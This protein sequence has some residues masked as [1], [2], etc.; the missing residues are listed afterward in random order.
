[1]ITTLLFD[2]VGHVDDE[3]LDLYCGRRLPP[4]DDEAVCQHL[5]VCGHCRNRARREAFFGAL[6]ADNR[7]LFEPPP[8]P[9]SQRRGRLFSPNL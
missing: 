2:P 9:A 8:T 6:V 1:M 5:A 4:A 3:S 7:D